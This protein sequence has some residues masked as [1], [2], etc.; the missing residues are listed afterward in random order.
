LQPF[1]KD[2][3]SLFAVCRTSAALAAAT[4]LGPSDVE[5]AALF[6]PA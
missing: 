1:G 5:D 3:F 4:V 2:D 6:K